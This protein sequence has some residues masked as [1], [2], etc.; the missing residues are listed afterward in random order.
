MDGQRA[1]DRDVVDAVALPTKPANFD[2]WLLDVEPSPWR[3][4]PRFNAHGIP[5]ELRDPTAADPAL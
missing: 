3:A 4:R 5:R 1:A 2:S